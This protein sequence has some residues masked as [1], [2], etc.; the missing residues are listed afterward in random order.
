[1][2]EFAGLQEILARF[3]GKDLTTT[4]VHSLTE[5]VKDYGIKMRQSGIDFPEVV[6]VILPAWGHIG[7]HRADSDES[8][9][10]TIIKNMIHKFPQA[11]P[12]EIA[13]AIRR[14]WPDYRYGESH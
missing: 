1:M 5:A 13:E 6:L 12:R 14:A 3:M 8:R 4:T 7:I 2:T 9:I 11:T 10:Q